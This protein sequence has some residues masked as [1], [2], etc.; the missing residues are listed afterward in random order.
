[1]KLI[2]TLT[3]KL[4]EIITHSNL[5]HRVERN[6]SIG[7][8]VNCYAIQALILI[9]QKYILGIFLFNLLGVLV[10][11]SQRLDSLLDRYFVTPGKPFSVL[12]SHVIIALLNFTLILISHYSKELFL[13]DENFGFPK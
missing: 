3:F 9:I 10:V 7:R 6:V 12:F 13:D 8:C 1:M 2:L 4:N 5:Q 11:E